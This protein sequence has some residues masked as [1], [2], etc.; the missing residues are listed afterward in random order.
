VAIAVLQALNMGERVAQL[1]SGSLVR[2][3]M[4]EVQRDLHWRDHV[5]RCR[6][7]SAPDPH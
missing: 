5:E 6:N 3:S 2:S 1:A 7:G 4:L